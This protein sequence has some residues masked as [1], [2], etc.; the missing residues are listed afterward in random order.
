[1][2]KVILCCAV[3]LV[4][5]VSVIPASA[6]ACENLSSLKLPN[7]TITAAEAVAAG[8]FAPAARG[9]RGGGNAFKDLPAFCRI[10]AT[11]KPTTDS[12]IKIEVWMP[13]AANWNGKFEAVGNGGWNGS[14]DD[15]ALATALRRGYAAA[16]TDTGHEGGAGVWMQSED[17]RVDFGSRAVH[18]M[19]AQGKSLINAY[20][21]NA[22]KLSYF[23]GC[24]A[25]GRQALKA[26]QVY[27]ADF[28]GIIGGAPALNTTGRAAF[29]VWIAQNMHKDDASYI[30]PAKYPAIHDAVL[31]ACDA[32]DGVK[33]RVIENPRVCKFDPKVLLCKAGDSSDCLTAA[34]VQSAETMYKPV[35]NSRTKKEIFPGLEYGS[36]MGW[37][38][39][40]GAQPF[41]I[42][43]QM[44]QFMMEK[45]ANFDYK[46]LNWDS[47]ATAVDKLEKGEI[48]AMDP[49]LKA[50]FARGGKMIQYHGWADQQIPSGSSVEYYQ[51]VL[52]TMGG[53]NKVKENYRL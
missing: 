28:D 2:T 35:V 14:I 53:A 13:A 25:G 3:L 29:A 6:A 44:Y 39:F 33:D 8:A 37:S 46:S 10:A 31:Q 23:N 52:K 50:F 18:E 15:N 41:G 24:S 43:T 21:G 51:S 19:T 40:G 7:T 38:T 45:G 20:Y 27:P 1:M 9:G 22:A 4:L 30:P 16:A 32:L 34:Q 11:V 26:S 17:K 49:N 47:D 48:N 5:V 12:D 36:E 42:G